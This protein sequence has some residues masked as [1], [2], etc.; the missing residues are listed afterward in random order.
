MASAKAWIKASRLRTL[1][2]AVTSVLMGTAIAVESGASF[3]KWVL[4]FATVVY[5][6]VLAN[7]ANEGLKST[8]CC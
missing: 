6:Q 4:G 7:Y 8:L 5:L 3:N 1:P 2:L